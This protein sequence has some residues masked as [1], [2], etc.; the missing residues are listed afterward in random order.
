MA[1][2]G[3]QLHFSDRPEFVAFKRGDGLVR[4]SISAVVRKEFRHTDA[5]ERVSKLVKIY[6]LLK[7]KGVP[8]VDTLISSDT[9]H[10]HPHVYLSPVGIETLPKSGSEA[11]CAVVC[12]L[13]AL[14]RFD[15]QGWFLIDWSDAGMAPTRAVIH[16]KESEH[17][18]RVRQDGHGAEVDIWGVGRYLEMLASRVTCGIAQ[19]DAV[20]QMGRRWVSDLTMSAAT[21]LDEIK[22]ARDLFITTT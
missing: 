18:P 6:D 15:G 10:D 16:L 20:Q 5:V 22:A 12:V 7:F 21:A 13:E 4:M 3:Q 8:N 17:S 11:F 2:L 1:W 9:E 19:P 14:K